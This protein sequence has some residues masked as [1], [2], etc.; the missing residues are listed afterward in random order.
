MEDNQLLDYGVRTEWLNDVKQI[1][2]EDAL[3]ALVDHLPREA[4]EA[5]LELATG[6]TPSGSLP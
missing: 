5:L 2:S 4:A 3:L 1:A 6:S